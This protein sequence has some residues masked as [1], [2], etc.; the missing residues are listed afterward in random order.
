MQFYYI[1][2]GDIKKDRGSVYRAIIDQKPYSILI[3]EKGYIRKGIPNLPYKA[4][5]HKIWF[6]AKDQKEPLSLLLEELKNSPSKFLRNRAKRMEQEFLKSAEAEEKDQ[7]AES[8][9]ISEYI[10]IVEKYDDPIDP[11]KMVILFYY[12]KG[13]IGYK[14]GYIFAYNENLRK[15]LP[16]N[17]TDVNFRDVDGNIRYNMPEKPFEYLNHKI[18]SPIDTDYDKALYMLIDSIRAAGLPLYDEQPREK[19]TMKA[20]EEIKPENHSRLKIEMKSEIN[21]KRFDK[22]SVG[23]VFTYKGIL[24]MKISEENSALNLSDLKIYTIE[25]GEIVIAAKEVALRVTM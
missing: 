13:Y 25:D 20:T 22:V 3:N 8:E 17:C 6:R 14:K 21:S 18:W 19:I 10:S 24:Y 9:P 23:W 16:R 5:N 2:G 4:E 11:E 1:Y 15:N 7:S 12:Y